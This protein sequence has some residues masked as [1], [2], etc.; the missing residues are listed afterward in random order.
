[1][2][3]FNLKA[4]TRELH[5]ALFP[6]VNTSWGLVEIDSALRDTLQA[7]E[8]VV[9]DRMPLSTPEDSEAQNAYCEAIHDAVQVIQRLQEGK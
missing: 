4:R 5:S 1:M 3:K 2:T 8:D 7:A 9:K 6:S